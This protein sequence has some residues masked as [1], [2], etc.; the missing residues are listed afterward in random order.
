MM[1]IETVCV[2]GREPNTPAI[3]YLGRKWAGWRGSPLAN[4][5][6]IGKDGTRNQVISKY[7]AWLW[8]IIQVKD[9]PAW[10]ELERLVN[11]HEPLIL[12]CWCRL[13]EACH[14]DVVKDAILYLR[15]LEDSDY[16]DE[17]ASGNAWHDDPGLW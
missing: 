3:T 12:G 1:P 7:K 14:R 16:N 9:S 4:Q 17:E 10:D 5:Y 15:S 6:R 2:R 11:T 8:Q 13:D